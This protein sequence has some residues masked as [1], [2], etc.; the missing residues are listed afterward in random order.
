M[1]PHMQ[2][3]LGRIAAGQIGEADVYALER[4]AAVRH[5]RMPPGALFC[6]VCQHSAVRFLPFGLAGRRQ[7]CCPRCGSLERHRFL[8]W[9]LGRHTDLLKRRHRVLHTAPEPCLRARIAT[10]PNL[11]Y[12]SVDRYDPAADIQAPLDCLP[13]ADASRDV[14]LTSHVLEHLRDDRAAL[15]ELARVLRPGGWMAVMV[16]YDPALPATLEDPDLDDP[17]ERLRRFGHP[18][19]FRIYGSDLPQR[20]AEAG[21]TVRVLDSREVLSGHRRRR[22][23]INRNHV[24][25]CTRAAAR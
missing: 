5:E 16:P 20:I 22:L 11:R 17:A 1:I 6:P 25:V 23:R 12:L 8:W 4:A 19:H 24:L 14:V 2:S 15:H 7:A 18:Y 21:F 13:L 10:L 3:L 9:V